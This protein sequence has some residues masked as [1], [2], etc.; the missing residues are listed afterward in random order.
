MDLN[1]F[2]S[3]AISWFLINGVKIFLVLVVSFVI[4]KISEVVISKAV[5]S[6]IKKGG[7]II[8]NGKIQKERIR[9]LTRV[10]RSTTKVIIWIIAIL[11]ILPELNINIAPLLAS[12]G[13]LGL[14]LGMG[15]RNIIQDYLAGIFILIEDQYRVGE[16][17]SIVNIKG[18]VVDIN[19]RRTVIKDETGAVH[20]IPNGQINR[21]TNFSRKE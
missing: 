9:T 18:D 16:S 13:I 14:A 2:L 17:I 11:T 4:S 5:S 1:S 7:K 3:Q 8:R 6:F 19:L 21:V 12:I 20:L 15:A 10:F